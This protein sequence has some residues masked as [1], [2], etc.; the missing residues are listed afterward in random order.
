MLIKIVV[1]EKSDVEG[2]STS[3]E[4]EGEV[5]L[6]EISSVFEQNSGQEWCFIKKPRYFKFC[7]VDENK[8][9]IAPQVSY[10]L[11]MDLET[12]LTTL[13][14][15]GEQLDLQKVSFANFDVAKQTLKPKRKEI[16]FFIARLKS[17]PSER[18]SIR[19]ILK[20]VTTEVEKCLEKE[21][22]AESE[23]GA[24]IS[25]NLVTLKFICEQLKLVS[26]KKRRYSPA[27]IR[28]AMMMRFYSSS[29]YNAI[30]DSKFMILPSETT[31]H[32]YTVPRREK[33]IH[34]ARLDELSKLAGTIPEKK[35]E[36][37]VIFDEMALQPNVNFDSSGNMEGFATNS[38]SDNP[39]LATSMLCFMVQ[40]LKQN[41][42][43]VVSFHPVHCLG[44]EFLQQCFLQVINLLMKAGF[45][46][47][48][49]VCDNHSVNRKMYRN[50]SGKTDKE[51]VLSPIITNPYDLSE[52]IVLIHDP[53]HILK[54]IRNNWFRRTEWELPATKKK[55]S[56]SL[57]E[58]LRLVEETLPVRQA[59]PLTVKALKPNNI[60]RQKV[61]LAFNV[62]S[63]PVRNA[64]LWYS[65]REPEVFSP[66]DVEETVRF[67]DS[68]R[69]FFEILNI[70][71]VKIGPIS[72]EDSPKIQTLKELQKY[73]EEISECGIFTKETYQALQQTLSGSLAIIKT[74]L[75]S[76]EGKVL[77]FTARFQQDPLE[78]HFGHQ[79][80]HSG[81]A[82][83]ITPSQFSQTERKLTNL[84][85]LQSN[86]TTSTSRERKIALQWNDEPFLQTCLQVKFKSV[87]FF[88]LWKF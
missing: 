8:F 6:E 20:L 40:G 15:Y 56:W 5:S 52:K 7:K 86:S 81:C 24:L 4:E 2:S 23:D 68:V 79:R 73:F 9:T 10:V 57:L 58:Q 50:L 16:E 1:T 71:H 32:S 80:L 39:P 19:D 21:D 61:K 75:C 60:E 59:H 51:L 63:W 45:K 11:M 26:N 69:T 85:S 77:V 84:A 62:V 64:L 37:S 22:V 3:T 46:P 66:P 31:L 44:S 35:R 27:L 33:G 43:E 76:E 78:E 14:H 29:G 17:L 49:A 67:M 38:T 70:N 36:V 34:Q 55:I 72:S 41:F 48:L 42:H 18:C 83:R 28:L 54:N 12:G 53:V 74:L 47:M 25:E 65:S 30:R 87:T 88:L 82:Y 13:H